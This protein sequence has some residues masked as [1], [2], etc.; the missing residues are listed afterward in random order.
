MQKL[1]PHR[2]AGEHH[3]GRICQSGTKL[4]DVSLLTTGTGLL[5][6]GNFN[7][8]LKKLWWSSF[9]ALIAVCAFFFL[10]GRAYANTFVVTDL[11]DDGPG[12]LRGA[13][14]FANSSIG[15]DVIT[16]SVTGTIHL[17]SELVVVD[18]VLIAGPDSGAVILDGGNTHRILRTSTGISLSM[19]KLTLRNG[20]GS[21]TVSSG[22][23]G[24]LLAAGPL[25]LDH[26][27]LD[28]N[29]STVNGAGISANQS[30]VIAR[31]TFSNNHGTGNGS[32]GG[33]LFAQAAL[34]ISDTQ[35]LSNS[36]TSG[37]GVYF[38]KADPGFIV[39]SLFARNQANLGSALFLDSQGGVTIEYTTIA[40]P[41]LSSLTT[42]YVDQG[43]L[44]LT[45]DI[46]ANYTTGIFKNR[47]ANAVN[48]DHCLFFNVTNIA[49]NHQINLTNPISGDPL[50]VNPAVDN[51]H[52]QLHS[53]AIDAGV[54]VGINT[55]FDGDRRPIGSGFDLGYDEVRMNLYLPLALLNN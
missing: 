17:A 31:S 54:D 40:S 32:Q 35:F 15:P 55:D 46:F 25:V 5:D 13:I 37:G 42:I 6:K 45:D 4:C 1:P 12:T 28:G 41:S 24:A 30:I 43:D 47:L 44:T 3:L 48:V 11:G 14:S 2:S 34:Q 22:S 10:K 16:F 29:N 33:G 39:N 26:V 51:Y 38:N 53:T 36:A 9:V 49:A 27:I 19:S 7:M 8:P 20:N 50:F 18:D 23:G 21:S 52:L